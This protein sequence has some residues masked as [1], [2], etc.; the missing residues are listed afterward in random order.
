MNT[1][2]SEIFITGNG[3]A[4]RRTDGVNVVPLAVLTA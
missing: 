4:H 1:E 2:R 3:F